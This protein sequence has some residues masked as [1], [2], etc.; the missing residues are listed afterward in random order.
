MHIRTGPRK[1]YA[2]LGLVFATFVGHARASPSHYRLSWPA[3]VQDQWAMLRVERL[4]SN[5]SIGPVEKRGGKDA[6]DCGVEDKDQRM[7]FTQ[8]G[9]SIASQDMTYADTSGAV[10]VVRTAAKGDLV[11][12]TCEDV[13]CPIPPR[14][15]CYEQPGICSADEWC[16]IDIHEKWG[17]WAMNRD[18]TTP[19]WEYCYNAAD[20]VA[21]STDEALISSYNADC[22][23]STV[24]D[25]G[26]KLGPKIEAW[27]PA[28]G[29]CVKF[30]KEDQSC[31]GN[32]LEFGPFE[33]EFG[34]NYFREENGWPFPR[35][36]VC[37]PGL[38]CTGADFDVRP[39][40]C[41]IQRP[42]NKC[43]Y[44][45][46]WDSTQCPRTQPGTPKGGLNKNQTVEALRRVVLL[47]PG[48]IASPGACPYWDRASKIGVSVL[49]TQHRFYN[50]IAALW[51]TE[52]FGAIPSFDEVMKLIPDPNLFGSPA[53]CVAQ[54]DVAGSP[55]NKALAEAGTLSNQPNQ[56]WSLVHFAMHN[57]P[58]PLSA[59]GVAASR[60]LAAHLSESFW[61]DDCRGFFTVGVIE[62][63]GLPPTS[64]NPEDHARWWW[65]GHNVAS[66]HVATTR[67]GHP[68]IHELGEEP[69]AAFQNPYFMTWKDAVDMWTYRT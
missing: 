31:I 44:G 29:R 61:C 13:F 60:A 36:L 69:A 54:A 37:G 64:S 4:S 63:Y 34:L 59:K 53:D 25:Y 18:G 12:L 65:W 51:P 10:P 47:Y 55:I 62:R 17:Q 50:I 28:R 40:T 8:A 45:P 32:P 26:I 35:P 27:K 9:C 20:F 3:A 48:E 56:V 5:D 30:R 58:S 6:I 43:F 57:Q 41:V 46:W 66:E 11:K 19:Q 16:M 52:L 42:V 1:R 21:N 14:L 2:M 23:A 39:S 68:W 15:D 33:P 22:V 49:A 67:A 38:T 7:W 24:G